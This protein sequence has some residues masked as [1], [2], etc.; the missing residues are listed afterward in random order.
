MPTKLLND[1]ISEQI[2]TLF[3]AHL[4]Y[5]V[6]LV[7]FSKKVDCDTCEATKQLLSELVALSNKLSLR[8]YVL[9][10]DPQLA[11]KFNVTLAPSLIVAGG[12]ED[13]QLDYGIRFSGIPSGYEFSSLIQAIRIVSTRDSGLPLE[14]REE[15]AAITSPIHLQV[16]VT[17]T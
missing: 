14:I 5:P 4:V 10:D 13:E 12:K 7:Y 15:L 9:E 17:P 3:D 16:F 6:E 8:E 2:K 1:E 11:H